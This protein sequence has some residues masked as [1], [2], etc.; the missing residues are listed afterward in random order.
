VSAGEIA[1]LVTLLI[2]LIPSIVIHEVAH[3]WVSEKLGDPT[4]RLY[5][6]ITLDPRAHIDPFW[7][8]IFPLLLLILSGFRFTFGMAKPVPINPRYYR[9]PT[10]GMALVGLAGPGAN[11]IFAS[12]LALLIRLFP[13]LY[14]FRLAA[15]INIVLAV[16]NLIPIPPLDGSRIVAYF[17]PSHLARSYLSSEKYGFLILFLLLTL[18]K[19]FFWA[20]IAPVIDFFIRIFLG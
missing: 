20:I 13:A 6:R 3:G 18:F 1:E 14:F 9:E 7:T 10:K 12:F 16:F 17:L 19:G 11:L 4:P 2:L 5:G 8:I 15:E